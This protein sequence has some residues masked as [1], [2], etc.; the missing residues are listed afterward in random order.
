[1]TDANQEQ[2]TIMNTLV[3]CKYCFGKVYLRDYWLHLIQCP[4]QGR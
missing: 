3:T 2:P 4:R 1:M